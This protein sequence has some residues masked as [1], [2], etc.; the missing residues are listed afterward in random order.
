MNEFKPNLL[1]YEPEGDESTMAS[2]MAPFI[3]PT[4]EKNYISF[5]KNAHVQSSKTNKKANIWDR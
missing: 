4:S 2:F 3:S 1:E 5:S